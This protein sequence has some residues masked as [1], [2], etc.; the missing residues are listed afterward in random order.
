MDFSINISEEIELL[1]NKIR[2]FVDRELEP[3]A[4][5]IEESGQ[6]PSDLFRIA[7]GKG[8]TGLGV[9]KELG[10]HGG[11]HLSVA[12]YIE[13]VSRSCPSFATAAMVQYLFMIPIMLFGT[14]QQKTKYIPRLVRGE[15]FAAHA[16]TE[17]SAGSDVAGIKTWAKK[18]GDGWLISGKKYFITLADKAD[19]FIVL[20]R[21]SEP[22]GEEQ[23]WRGLTAFIVEKTARGLEVG[24]KIRIMGMRGAE[25]SELI[26]DNVWVPSDSVVGRVGEGFKV[27]MSTYNYGRLYVSAQAVGIAQSALERCLQYASRRETFGQPLLS[28]QSIQFSIVDLL[29]SIVTARLM[30]Y[31]AATLLDKG[32]EAGIIAAALAKLYSTEVAEEAALKAIEM[33]GGAGV[34]HQ[35]MV[36]KHLRDS[37]VAKIYEGAPAML[38][39]TVIR[40]LMKQML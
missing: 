22:E 27:A 37:Q 12:M 29:K 26:L 16:A 25:P 40:Q 9:P 30:T 10:G 14:E 31:W 38:R 35:G 6:I 7:A 2:E 15:K 36:E 19:Y 17:E 13:E 32:K 3:R 24:R 23:R 18:E 8:F 28:F 34:I 4:I 20:A 39:L 1:R 33:H 5:Q 21:T 11:G